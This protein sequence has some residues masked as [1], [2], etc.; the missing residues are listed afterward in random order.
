VTKEASTAG[1]KDKEE[2][3][4]PAAAKSR[5]S[6]AQAVFSAPFD[7]SIP[8]KRFDLSR[9]ADDIAMAGASEAQYRATNV[10]YDN[11]FMI[12]SKYF[13]CIIL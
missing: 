5:P 6:D 12:L 1:G 10:V 8:Q 3:K 13:S 9:R 11:V 7:A 2:K 4:T